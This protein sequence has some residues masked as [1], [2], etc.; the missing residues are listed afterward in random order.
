M[1]LPGEIKYLQTI[2]VDKIVQIFPFDPKVSEA[3]EEIIFQIHKFFPG[4]EIIHMGASGLKISGQN[5]LDLYMLAPWQEFNK[6][7]NKLIE[8]F[9]EPKSKKQDSVAW[10][11]NRNGF[12]V[13]L[14]LTDPSSEPMQAQISVYQILKNNPQLLK[15]YE[16]LKQAMNGKDFREYQEKKYEFYHRILDSARMTH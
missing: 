13:E 14:Y 16:N 7:L 3:A 15:E 8:I 4:L 2:P 10:E 6:Y 11:F 5:D 12:P 1:L 9:G